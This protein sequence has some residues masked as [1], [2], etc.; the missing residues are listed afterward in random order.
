MPDNDG[1]DVKDDGLEEDQSDSSPDESNPDADS[2]EAASQPSDK[3]DEESS[4]RKPTKAEERI[5]EL[6]EENKRLRLDR[7]P[8]PT[9]SSP[10]APD[11]SVS[12][13][14]RKAADVLHTKMGF[15]K[16]E[17]LETTLKSELQAMQDR[18]VLGQTHE[19]L[20]NRYNGSD[21]LP[22]YDRTVVED[23]IRKTGILN[24]E[25]AY[26][27]LYEDELLDY[28]VKQ[29]MKKKAPYS[30][31]PGKPARKGAPAGLKRE[32][33]AN[34]TPAEYDK[35]RAEILKLVASGEL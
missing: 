19:R 2:A 22:K 20:E 31:Q 15:I 5:R 30:E 13:E 8:A 17:D 32:D 4:N 33:I 16:R 1:T 9:P 26:K 29:I 12:E 7:A 28:H 34:M 21:N 11:T 24:P 25:A 35:N 6:I 18:I 23:H 27:D 3:G 10:V 14:A